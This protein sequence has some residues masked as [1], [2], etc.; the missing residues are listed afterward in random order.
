MLSPQM[1][2]I[3]SSEPLVKHKIQI[4]PTSNVGSADAAAAATAGVGGRETA[5]RVSGW[6]GRIHTTGSGVSHADRSVL[7]WLPAGKRAHRR[8]FQ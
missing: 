5:D 1:P 7:A 6:A 2:S 4:K 8:C 3:S